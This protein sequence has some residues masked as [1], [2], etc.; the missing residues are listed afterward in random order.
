MKIRE[1]EVL[2]YLGCGGRPADERLRRTVASCVEALRKACTP[3]SV[4]R[5]FPAGFPAGGV[6]IGNLFF[7]GSGLRNHIRGCDKAVL[8]AATLGARADIL[9]LQ[10]SKTDMSR[11]AVL[12][13][14]AA[15][16]TESYCDEQDAKI[17][18]EAAK[19]G[20]YLRP[21]YSPGYGDFS[22]AHQRDILTT[23]DCPRRIGLS[24][25]E[26]CMLVPTKSVTAVIG[27]TPEKSGCTISKCMECNS[28]NCPFRKETEDESAQ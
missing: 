15:A 7:P 12:Q 17:A 5:V 10:A 13:A 16:M 2:R 20:L 11:A 9:L 25:T 23:L 19:E 8:F 24:M 28:E 22:I 1:E 26:S 4:A 14:A 3:R 27:L 18:A 21:R 6:R